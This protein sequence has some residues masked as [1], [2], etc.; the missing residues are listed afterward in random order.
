MSDAAEPIFDADGKYLFFRA[1]TNSG[2][3]KSGLDM[4]SNDHPVTYN[5]YIAVLRKDLPSPFQPES[6]EE[7]VKEE[8]TAKEQTTE[9]KI[10]E[11]QP[12][13]K[14]KEE[15]RIDFDNIDQRIIALPGAAGSYSIKGGKLFYRLGS[16]IM[17][18]DFNTRSAETFMSGVTAYTISADQKKVLFRAGSNWGIGSTSGRPNTSEG[19]LDLSQF[20]I[21]IEPRAE[22]AQMFKE[23][24]RLNRDFF[25]A[26][27][28]H[29]VDWKANYERYEPYLADLAHRSDLNYLLSEMLGELCVGHSYVRGGAMPSV[30]P[31]P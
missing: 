10:A 11:G 1:S 12:Q 16:S 27:N 3:T 9:K 6:D 20:Q 26:P 2:M 14:P 30:P 22:W 5:I 23:A 18:Y 4:T 19:R 24:W 21:L 25:Y 17:K 28:M 13:E 8:K 29:G 15:F 7:G 31:P